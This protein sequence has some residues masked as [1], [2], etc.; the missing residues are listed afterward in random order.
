MAAPVLTYSSG[1]GAGDLHLFN[2]VRDAVPS[3]LYLSSKAL[4]SDFGKEGN[5][6]MGSEQGY[7]NIFYVNITK[8]VLFIF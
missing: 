3:A 4:Y 1:E 6:S 8:C 7:L 5:Y 2:C